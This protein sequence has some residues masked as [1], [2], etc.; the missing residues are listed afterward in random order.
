MSLWR[1]YLLEG[2]YEF[3]K[4]VRLPGFAVPVLLFPVMLYSLFG[5]TFGAQMAGDFREAEAFFLAMYGTFG[6][7]GAALFGFGVNVASERGLGWM[8]VKRASPMPPLAYFA[9]KLMMALLFG[10]IIIVALF[11][12][13][14]TVGNV[15]LPVPRWAGLAL[16]LLIG[17][18]PFCALGLAIGYSVGPSGAAA[19][20]NLIYLPMSFASGL[21][22]PIDSLPGWVQGIAPFLPAYHL[23]QLALSQIGVPSQ[24]PVLGHVLALAGFTVLFLGM[25]L[26]GYR[27]DER[28]S[29][30]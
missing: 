2:R 17:T 9:G 1:I 4:T 30:A 29:Y 22:I 28:N 20:V 7:I 24:L 12:L 27:R 19:L 21:W 15:A 18:F 5:L 14:A 3:L 8:E 13:G 23:A 16:G 26:V 11:T 10:A 25:A 6:V